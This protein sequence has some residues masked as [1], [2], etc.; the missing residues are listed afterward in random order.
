MAAA[1]RAVRARYRDEAAARGVRQEHDNRLYLAKLALRHHRRGEA[2][3]RYAQ[4]ATQ[5]PRNLLWAF[6]A[7]TNPG[8]ADRAMDRRSARAVPPEWR[9]EVSAWLEPYLFDES[10]VRR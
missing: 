10:L 9:R 2:F 7:L 4:L 1:G 5:S 6:A 3:L 8:V